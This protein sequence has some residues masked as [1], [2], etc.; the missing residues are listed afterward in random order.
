MY[1]ALQ[2]SNAK[3]W[4][5]HSAIIEHGVSVLSPNP[6]NTN[7]SCIKNH[8]FSTPQ[9]HYWR[10]IAILQAAVCIWSSCSSMA[11]HYSFFFV[12]EQAASN[13]I[14]CL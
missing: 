7:P 9:A 3:T 4:W 11:T 10:I 1:A 12:C 6:T 5:V 8:S 14:E 13:T 2:R